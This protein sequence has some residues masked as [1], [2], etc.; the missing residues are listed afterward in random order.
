MIDPGEI[1][2][3]REGEPRSSSAERLDTKNS[4]I[5]R[6]LLKDKGVNVLANSTEGAAY[7]F[8]LN[9]YHPTNISR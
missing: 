5:A 1:H 8:Y 3:G 2:G 6:P 9:L 7:T 4:T